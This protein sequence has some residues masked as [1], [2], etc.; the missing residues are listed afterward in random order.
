MIASPDPLRGGARALPSGER[1][2]AAVIDFL[3]LAVP[4]AV[5][6]VVIV[7]T[8]SQYHQFTVFLEAHSKATN[9]ASN[10]TFVRLSQHLTT[11]AT[12]FLYASEAVTAAYL[13]FMYLRFGATLGKLALGLRI[14]RV[15]GSPMTVR[16]AVLR[17]TVFWI[18]LL[19][20]VI[21]LWIWL[22]EYMAGT[23]VVLF[24]PDHRGPEDL[25]G[26]TIVVRRESAGRSLSELLN[27]A[28]PLA[29]PGQPPS[30]QGRGGHL[31]G[32]G[33]SEDRP[34]TPGTGEPEEG[35]I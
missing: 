3:V 14:T 10:P 22:V 29:P 27:Y 12:E 5:L 1:L 18:P 28:P 2:A 31:P 21:G 8:S 4:Q 13:I 11:V 20:P 26:H 7:L 24:R 30:P 6:L 15:D 34:P 19:V 33:P 16:N 32:W 9:L 35:R 23:V 25:L 17:S